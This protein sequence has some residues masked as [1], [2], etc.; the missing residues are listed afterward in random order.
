MPRQ[1]QSQAQEG[2]SVFALL[3]VLAVVGGT[4][5]V[6]LGLLYSGY[7]G[8]TELEPT[9]VEVGQ[10]ELIVDETGRRVDYG[11]S[12]LARRGGLWVLHFE[13][14]PVDIGDAHGHLAGRLFRNV[15]SRVEE[16]LEARYR[17]F[18]ASW[19]EL[20]L[21]RWDY[22]EADAALGPDHQR[23]LSALAAALPS[24]GEG[25][26]EPYHRLFLYQCFLDLTQRLQDV[27]VE[28][29]MFAVAPR[30]TSAGLEAGNLIIGRTLSVDF[31]PKFEADRVVA[32]YYP[33]GK[34]PFASIGW[35]GL[36][37]VVTGVNARGIFVAA[38]PARA[39]DARETD[40]T[41]LPLVLRRV[42]EEADTLEQAVE[43]IEA[44]ELRTAGVVL[45][46]DGV[47]RKAVILEA[48]ARVSEDTRLV[49][50][51]DE[52]AIWATDHM[53]REAFEADAHNER[54]RRTT[55]SGYR[56]E[57]LAEL[58]AAP[59]NFSPEDA[60]TVLRDRRGLDNI[61]LGL[62][63]RN[64]LEN[65][66]T[67]QSIVL[68]ATS[69]VL[70]VAEGPS[71]LGRYRAFD[72]RHLLGRQG[73]RPAALADFP[74]D[75]LLYSEEYR[76]YQEALEGLDYAHEL[77]VLDRPNEALAAARVSLALAPDIGELH[78]LLG[79]IERELDDPEQ[80]K[81]HYRRYLEL[82]PGRQRDQER[83]KGIIEEL[84]G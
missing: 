35:A 51:D 55:S 30:A 12:W 73:S 65:L 41:P 10:H 27:V 72:L 17:G 64:A 36:V 2:R 39:D 59:G 22:R 54:I 28:G 23:E 58:L 42:L 16:L 56:Y 75:R 1:F 33:D 18:L 53:I 14:S 82:I 83:V 70:W 68:D 31:G 79:D 57:R 62:G 26:L 25:E 34:Y 52:Q 81:I 8:Y 48:A 49:R 29:S 61:E 43:I 45:I 13:G 21:L 5:A 77:L 7:V 40:A 71:T 6:L 24:D 50:G 67:M 3:R 76:D 9:E 63:N 11:R 44:A 38:N 84:G 69:M 20:M 15:D 80:A 46:G 74:A 66:H 60:V 19:A 4:F 47:Q 32:F 78:R 37:G